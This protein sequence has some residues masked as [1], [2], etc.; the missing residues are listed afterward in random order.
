MFT[1]S[2]DINGTQIRRIDAVNTGETERLDVEAFDKEI[3]LHRYRVHDY[4]FE[5]GRLRR[6]EVWHDR[7]EGAE[8]LASVL[9]EDAYAA[10]VDPDDERT[11]DDK[12]E[13][14]VRQGKM[15]HELFFTDGV[16]DDD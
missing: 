4:D 6:S 12:F 2:I 7:S 3:T 9:A 10:T 16:D 14:V 11:I 1:L 8:G 5:A 15:I 13:D